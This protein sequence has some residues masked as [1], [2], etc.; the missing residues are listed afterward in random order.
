MHHGWC[1]PTTTLLPPA[2]TS[3]RAACLSLSFVVQ[4]AEQGLAQAVGVSN[5]KPERVRKAAAYLES[6][7]TCL[8]SNQVQYSLLYRKPETNGVM[9]ACR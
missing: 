9:E 4:V 3:Q 6:R 2:E 5:F 1:V 7:G 8:S